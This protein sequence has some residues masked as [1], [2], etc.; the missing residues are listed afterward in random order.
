LIDNLPRGL[1]N[2]NPGNLRHST[3]FTWHGELAPDA[4]G[5]CRFA[6]DHD[7]I[8]ALALDLF[9]KWDR[10]GL[11]SVH[12]IVGRY[13]PPRENDTAAYITRVAAALGVAPGD[14]LDL[15]DGAVLARFVKAVIRQ[16]CGA[17]PYTPAAIAAAVADA[18]PPT[19]NGSAA[20]PR[21]AQT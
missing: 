7:G 8:R 2:R 19:S 20:A 5:Y 15:Q 3:A 9:T 1:R 18:L 14:A 16:E 21:A 11:R 12:A 10:D 13:A 17:L 6:Q 4:E